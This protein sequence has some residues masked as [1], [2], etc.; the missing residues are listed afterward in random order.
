MFAW[1]YWFDW[2]VVFDLDAHAQAH[3]TF[4]KNMPHAHA[5]TH[6][7]MQH[8]RLI[9]WL[10]D[11]LMHLLIAWLFGCVW[12]IDSICRLLD[13][14]HAASEWNKCTWQ[15]RRLIV[16][17]NDGCLYT[18]THTQIPTEIVISWEKE[19]ERPERE[20]ERERDSFDLC[21]PMAKIATADWQPSI[22]ENNCTDIKDLCRHL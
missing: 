2:F 4:S 1:C 13:W 11:W 17:F 19:K 16:H 21:F 5:H 15:K 7:H 14:S 22:R 12:L 9:A 3:N 10:L 20:R 6:T 8:Q 18:H